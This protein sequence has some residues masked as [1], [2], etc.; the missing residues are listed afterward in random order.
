MALRRERGHTTTPQDVRTLAIPIVRSC[1]R[2]DA[3]R[4]STGPVCV[5]IFSTG[6]VKD[7][8]LDA[9]PDAIL[10]KTWQRTTNATAAPDIEATGR[11][12]HV[13]KASIGS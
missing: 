2:P 11:K 9:G 6:P 7:D 3:T 12:G 8:L 5:L 1:E 13:G 10:Y 4:H